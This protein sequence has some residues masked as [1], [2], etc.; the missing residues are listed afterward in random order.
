M[1]SLLRKKGWNP[2]SKKTVYW[3]QWTRVATVT[4]TA[5]VRIM[6]RG[7]TFSVGEVEGIMTD[8]SQHICDQLLDGNEVQVD[9]LGSFRLKVSCKSQDDA[10]ELSAQGADVSVV[11]E[12]DELLRQRL[13][14]EAEF[15]IV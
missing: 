13:R 8:F 1:I 4:K 2:Q 11:F 15:Q 3:L 6:S 14:T 12:P 7:S 10:R 5:L 9:G